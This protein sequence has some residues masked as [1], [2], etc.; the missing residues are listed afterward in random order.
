MVASN[1]EIANTN[2]FTTTS[3]ISDPVESKGVSE[4]IQID[5]SRG[6]SA[7][8]STNSLREL[9][10]LSKVSSI[11]YLAHMEAQSTDSNW[12]SQI[13]DELF[14]LLYMTPKGGES[15]IYSPPNNTDSMA[16]PHMGL[17][18]NMHPQVPAINSSVSSLSYKELQPGNSNL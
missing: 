13:K 12:A 5:A 18:Y 15:N 11:K 8:A 2:I 9:S 3:A 4:N 16:P 10:V 6:K 14:K 7:I 1:R 17:A